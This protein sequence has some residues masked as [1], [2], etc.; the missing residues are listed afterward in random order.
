VDIRRIHLEF[1]D[2]EVERTQEFVLRWSPG[3]AIPMTE[4]VRQQWNFSPAGAN[5]QTEDFVVELPAVAV[6]ELDITPDI[7]GGNVP[8]TLTRLRL[9]A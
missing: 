6:L 9:A 8:A 5:S 3:S 2:V 4:I 1:L 7:G